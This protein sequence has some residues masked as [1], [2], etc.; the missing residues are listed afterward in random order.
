[1]GRDKKPRASRIAGNSSAKKIISNE[2]QE[3]Q[4]LARILNCNIGKGWLFVTLKYDDD[5][6]P[7]D[8]EALKKS[9]TKFLRALRVAFRAETGRVPRYIAVNGV[10]STEHG[11]PARFHHHI[12]IEPC[13]ADML[14]RVW[15]GGGSVLCED[16]D[17]R[18]DHTALAVYLCRNAERTRSGEKC[19]STSRNN[20]AKPI[21]TE[22]VE[23]ESI[24]GIEALPGSTIV[25]MTRTEAENGTAQSTYIRC[26]L[27]ERPKVRAGRLILPKPPKRGGKKLK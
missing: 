12:V 5:H 16:V 13:S 1:M 14:R 7:A 8:R 18:Q 21:Y 10:R 26:I 3:M 27:P 9:L 11:G 22:P 24:D 20:L 23:V 19:W 4:R 6:L 15:H 25:E 2:R 17:N